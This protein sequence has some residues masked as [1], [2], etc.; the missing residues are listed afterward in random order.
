MKP[1]GPIPPAFSGQ[2]GELEI[3]GIPVSELAERA[4]RTPFFVYDL[5]LATAQV[6]RFRAALPA[7]IHLHFAVKANPHPSVIQHLMDKTDGLDMAS[8]G[9]LERVR[10]CGADMAHVSFAGPG[11]RDPELEL[12]ISL[13]ATLNL[14]S[15]TE[16][17]RALAIGHRLGVTPRLAVRVNPDFE[18]KGSGMSMGGGAKPFGVDQE[19]VPALVE[20]I[21]GKG[22]D[23]RGFHIYSGSQSLD[24]DAISESQE[25][26]IALAA[27]LALAIGEAPKSVNLGGG[28]GIPYTAN[29]T[30][31][32]VE[33]VGAR[34]SEALA[35]RD[36]IL[37]DTQFM[38]ELGRWLIGEA[39]VY[40]ARILDRKMSKGALFLVTD[41][42]MHHHLAA[43]GN[44]GMVMKRNYPVAIASHMDGEAVEEATV[45]GPLCTPLD[46]LAADI[47]VPRAEIGDYVAVFASGA[48][49][50]S[51]SPVNFLSHP[52]AAEI[53]VKGG[54]ITK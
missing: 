22:A 41:G 21:L 2:Q 33:A 15:E 29:D 28:F 48:Y 3:G 53:V 16:A 46:R 4:G 32:D 51:A 39:G 54:K 37:A 35:G 14:E 18:L 40:I 23:W 38:I 47:A 52:T 42:G 19:R 31:L 34:L 44:F 12:A 24:A 11:K 27:K 20:H 7:E 43:S 9:E 36:P 50:L 49:G 45:V 5:D 6:E 17:E 26:S 8:G 1:I 30:P 10:D 25:A 13:G